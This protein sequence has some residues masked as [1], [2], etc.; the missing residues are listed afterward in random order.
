MLRQTICKTRI[1]VSKIMPLVLLLIVMIFAAIPANA[2]NPEPDHRNYF[3]ENLSPEG[4]DALQVVVQYS[5]NDEEDFTSGIRPVRGAVIVD[6]TNTEDWTLNK[7]AAISAH[8]TVEPGAAGQIDWLIGFQKDATGLN[9]DIVQ[10]TAGFYVS[11]DAD[12]SQAQHGLFVE[13]LTGGSENYAITIGESDIDQNLIHVGVTDDPQMQWDE[14]LDSFHF[15]K[16]IV[17]SGS[18]GDSAII[19][20]HLGSPSSTEGQVAFMDNGQNRAWIYWNELTNCLVVRVGSTSNNL[21]CE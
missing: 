20:N 15:T 9:E 7:N 2:Q 14:S 8:N 17:S 18:Y 21:L 1:R 19:L 13:D 10:Q 12:G 4:F 5:Q 6:S 3:V 16:R 11:N